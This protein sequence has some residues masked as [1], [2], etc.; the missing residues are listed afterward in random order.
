MARVVENGSVSDPFPVTNGVKQGCVLAPNLFSLMFASML[1][2]ALSNSDAGITVRYRCDG[3]FFDLRRL[4]AKTK[5]L[6]ALVRDFLFYDCALAALNEPDLQELAT[7][8][9]TAAKAFGLTISLLKTEVMLQPAPGLSPPEPS[10]VIEDATLKKNV[11]TLTYLGSC[12]SSTCSM[13]KE[14]SS[15]LAKAG[16][17]FAKLWNRVWGVRGIT[18]RTKLAVYK[19]VV[20]TSLLY[21][22]ETWTL[23]RKQLRTLDPFHLRC[24]RKIM[25]ISWEDRISNTEVLR[26]ANMPGIE[27][28]IMKAR[29]RWVGHLVRMDDT[30]L[31]KMVFFSELQATGARNIGRPLKRYKDCLKAS[32]GACGIQLQG[33][34]VLAFDRSA[35]RLNVHK[36]VKAFEEKRLRDLDQKRLSRKDRRPDPTT[37]VVCPV[38]GCICASNFGLRSHLRIH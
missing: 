37:A 21:G 6:D 31:P 15:R 4:K 29:L 18:L 2:S 34:E 36:G 28:L 16:A 7:C 11:E 1:F 23:Y 9:S 38:C 26:R 14:V 20:V 22:C 12:L 8:L 30:R 17:S 33:W 19:A 32:L 10:I 5:A 25:G 3:R 24:L 35:W 13:D 27:A